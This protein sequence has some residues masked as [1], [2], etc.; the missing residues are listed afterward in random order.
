MIKSKNLYHQVLDKGDEYS[1]HSLMRL[2]K[3]F[4]INKASISTQEFKHNVVVETSAVKRF[5]GTDVLKV[6]VTT[7]NRT[8]VTVNFFGLNTINGP[9]PR[10]FIEK[11]AL[12]TRAGD[13]S[14]HR[15]IT[16]FNSRL[17][18]LLFK[19]DAHYL[20]PL[21]VVEAPKSYY[22]ETLKAFSGLYKRRLSANQLLSDRAV[23]YFSQLLWNRSAAGLEKFVSTFFKVRAKVSM[24]HGRWYKIS[25]ND[26][27]HLS[28]QK[29][30]NNRLGDTA[31]LG[32]HFWD[33]NTF[34]VLKISE[35]SLALY[36][37]FLKK[38]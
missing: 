10:P 32:G 31:C 28:S 18:H 35:L 33:Q 7:D 21:T 2:L 13:F 36:E 37:S 29:P 4:H 23:I 38:E 5:S 22:G 25:P 14:F 3:V 9:L 1:F 6:A 24:N 30:K 8:M 11:I 20:L 17:N 19:V 26:R 34:F 12:L 16:L 15:F 27:T